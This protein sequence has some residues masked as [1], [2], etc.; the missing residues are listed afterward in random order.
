MRHKKYNT[1]VAKKTGTK[2]KFKSYVLVALL[3]FASLLIYLMINQ[4]KIENSNIAG[5]VISSSGCKEVIMVSPSPTPYDPN[6]SYSHKVIKDGM[7]VDYVQEYCFKFPKD[8]FVT[9]DGW[10]SSP[11]SL[12]LTSEGRKAFNFQR[13]FLTLSASKNSFIDDENNKSKKEAITAQNGSKVKYESM[14]K[15][16]DKYTD[17]FERATFFFKSDTNDFYKRVGYRTIWF[18]PKESVFIE[19]DLY[20]HPDFEQ[21]LKDYEPSYSDIVES[22]EFF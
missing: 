14:M 10:L 19:L 22:L 8:D 3:I 16:S 6:D 17:E 4:R 1:V 5:N 2:N 21:D 15:V 18:L 11:Q 20:A 13:P 12:I 9:I 7:Y